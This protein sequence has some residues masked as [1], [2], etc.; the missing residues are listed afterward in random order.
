MSGGHAGEAGVAAAGAVEVRSV[1]RGVCEEGAADQVADAAG[2]EGAGRL[3]V[4]EF[5]EDAALVGWVSVV[6]GGKGYGGGEV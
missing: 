2:F 4:L 6:G 5:E 1:G 3:E